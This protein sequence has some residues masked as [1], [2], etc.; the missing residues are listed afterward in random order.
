MTKR[1]QRA[2]IQVV[3]QLLVAF[4]RA[5]STFVREGISPAINTLESCEKEL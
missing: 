5:T 1:T 4:R 2:L 3:I